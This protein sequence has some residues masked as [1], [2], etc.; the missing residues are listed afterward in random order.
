MLLIR[1]RRWLPVTG[2]GLAFAL[3][4]TLLVT[5]G[6][7]RAQVLAA[8]AGAVMATGGGALLR[9]GFPRRRLS[10]LHHL[11]AAFGF[12]L[13]CAGAVAMLAGVGLYH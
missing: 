5:S 3:V 12:L 11:L 4:P 7:P 8:A 13:L 1:S 2:L 9:V 6:A 10:D